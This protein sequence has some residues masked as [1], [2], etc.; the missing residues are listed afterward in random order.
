MNPLIFNNLHQFINDLTAVPDRGVFIHLKSQDKKFIFNCFKALLDDQ[1]RSKL[2]RKYSTLAF[3][4]ISNRI[5]RYLHQRTLRSA[6]VSKSYSLLD[7]TLRSYLSFPKAIDPHLLENRSIQKMNFV[8]EGLTVSKVPLFD[9][10]ILNPLDNLPHVPYWSKTY[11]EKR[12]FE[13]MIFKDCTFDYLSFCG[14]V[15]IDCQFIRCS[16][17]GSCFNNCQLERIL[18]KKANLS[19]AFF[20]HSR[21]E[22]TI[23][24]QSCLD[25]T[26]FFKA[27]ADDVILEKTSTQ[28]V[29]GLNFPVQ[30]PLPK[31]LFP[32]NALKPGLSCLT[33]NAVL[34]SFQSYPLKIDYNLENVNP[35]LLK[36]E[37]S[38]ALGK[39]QNPSERSLPD[40]V[41]ELCQSYPS[42]YPEIQKIF[43][44]ASQLI[45]Q[46]AD[47]L[48]LP[49]GADVEPEFY[50]QPCHHLTQTEPDYRR[51]LFEFSLLKRAYEKKI[52]ILGL[53]RGSQIGNIFFGGTLKQHVIN[54]KN[55]V[56]KYR[57]EKKSFIKKTF[58]RSFFIKGMSLHHQAYDKV[59]S[60]FEIVISYED[61]PKMLESRSHPTMIFSQFHPEFNKGTYPLIKRFISLIKLPAD[62]HP[63]ASTSNLGSYP[64][65]ISKF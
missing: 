35:D 13:N 1:V 59:S 63:S 41:L 2:S 45:E 6:V 32:W 53:C 62:S 20:E 31:L 33:L 8:I 50:G 42:N 39:A 28:S 21:L 18:F 54:Q 26:N 34:K 49:G 60:E 22:R 44:F 19:D 11:F 36:A 12:N 5:A 47:A 40:A 52:P 64:G 7:Q 55:V 4:K 25:Y 51:T 29:F 65:S 23:F 10:L 24:E 48:I 16:F 14:S 3:L 58:P 43:T 61:I 57:L 38:T 15:F 17:Q 56:Q 37:V 30:N 9:Q 46:S 27:T